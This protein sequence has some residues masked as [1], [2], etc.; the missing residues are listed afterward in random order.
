MIAKFLTKAQE[1]NANN[2][3]DTSIEDC[4]ILILMAERR[5]AAVARASEP[6]YQLAAGILC[7]VI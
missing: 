3:F 5:T 4:T 1:P 7:K 2:G 6:R